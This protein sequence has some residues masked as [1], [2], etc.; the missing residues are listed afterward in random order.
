MT[1]E[2]LLSKI[3]HL[4]I[5]DVVRKLSLIFPKVDPVKF[6]GDFGDVATYIGDWHQTYEREHE[7]IF[8]PLAGLY[9]LIRRLS[10][11]IIHTVGALG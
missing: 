6:D 3:F 11:G 8:Q 4:E 9:T 5:D 7:L 2:Q 10:A 1:R